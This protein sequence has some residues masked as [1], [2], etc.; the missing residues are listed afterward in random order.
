MSLCFFSF[1]LPGFN[2]SD[3]APLLALPATPSIPVIT[4]NAPSCAL[5]EF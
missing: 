3:F 4:L 1:T 2:L 5:D